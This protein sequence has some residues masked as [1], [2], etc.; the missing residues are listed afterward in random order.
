[1]DRRVQKETII[2][3]SYVLFPFAVSVKLQWQSRRSLDGMIKI[4]REKLKAKYKQDRENEVK[5]SSDDQRY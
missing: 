4:K 5:N 1:M 2:M 3:I